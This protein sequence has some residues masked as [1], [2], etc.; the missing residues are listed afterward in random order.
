MVEDSFETWVHG[1]SDM[2]PII[3]A[4]FI[5]CLCQVRTCLNLNVFITTV[6]I[7]ETSA[8]IILLV[9]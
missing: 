8:S 5:Y 7:L 4:Y 9:E 2:N 6:K 3:I 1:Q